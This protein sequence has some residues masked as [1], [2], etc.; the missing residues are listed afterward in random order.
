MQDLPMILTLI[1][2]AASICAY[3]SEKYSIETIALAT[4]AALITIFVIVPQNPTNQITTKDLIAGFAHPAL[5]TVIA[6][7]V[8]GQ[9]LF[10]TNAL[11]AP[12]RTITKLTGK[13]ANLTIVVILLTTIIISAFL[14]NTPVIV[15]FIPIVIAIA[16]QK[17]FA[18]ARALLPLSYAGILGGMTTL[19]GS[20]TNLLVA[21]VAQKYNHSINFF[22]F[23]AIGLIL[24]VTGL[25]YITTIMPVI[26][27]KQKSNKTGEEFSNKQFIAQIKITE[28]HPLNGQ[29][30][31]A[32]IFVALK[33]ITIMSI[34]R[35]NKPILP[36]FDDITLEQDDVVVVAATRN[37]LTKALSEGAADLPEMNETEKNQNRP[38]DSLVTIP[39]NF[40]VAEAVVAP[41]SQFI[42]RTV[43]NSKIRQTFGTMILG[44]QRRKGM[45]RGLMRMTRLEAGD[46]LLLGGLPNDIDELRETREILLLERS[47][48]EI[49]MRKYAKTA[50]AIFAAVVVAAATGITSIEAASIIGAFAVIA[51][52]CISISQAAKSFNLQIVM[53]IGASLAAATA[54]E[55]T[56]GSQFIAQ[57]IVN[58]MQGQN[59]IYIISFLFII[60]A[61]L[62][63]ILS[64]NATAVLMSPIA[65]DLAYTINAPIEPFI[66]CIIFA[67]NCSFATPMGYQTNLLVMGPGEYRFSDYIKAGVPLIIILWIT[68]TLITPIWYA[69]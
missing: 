57:I 54:L 35:D 63:N 61:I 68:F 39:Q 56:G 52:K 22:D 49:T 9:A 47:R 62:T 13:N 42:G 27:P 16:K 25:I 53:I 67:A 18:Q 45:G 4:L 46:T 21:G 60:T 3:V 38:T 12:A 40:T 58:S 66:F 55:K 59:T 14:N 37:N 50:L 43:E 7:L 11:E 34:H 29:K 23:T 17:N 36:P 30:N 5:F 20:S 69:L 44:L 51:T 32:G 19:I 28:N 41:Q 64:N 33:G 15:M 65:I 26:M 31:V 6:L 10:N 48:Q 8:I 2:I 24:A 1:V